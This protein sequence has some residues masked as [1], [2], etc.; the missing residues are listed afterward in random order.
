MAKSEYI[1]LRV[2]PWEKEQI[3]RQARRSGRST[4]DYVRKAALGQTVIEAAP[5]RELTTELRRQGNNLNQLV[6]MARQ[7]RLSLV[8][9]K[10][11][12][13]VYRQTWQA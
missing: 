9:L 2:V 3:E 4:S 13:E 12:L 1:H 10:P 8:D 7:G 11:F 5:L 6:V